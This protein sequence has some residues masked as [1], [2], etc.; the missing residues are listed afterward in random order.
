M[1]ARNTA[2]FF[3]ARALFTSLSIT[4][5]APSETSEQSVRLSGP[6]TSGFLSETL[7]QLF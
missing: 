4:A 2:A 3:M 5:E 1:A 6:V 7:R